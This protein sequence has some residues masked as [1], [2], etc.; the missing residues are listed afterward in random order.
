MGDGASGL[1]HGWLAAFGGHEP[2]KSLSEGVEGGHGS[3]RRG[4]SNV[5]DKIK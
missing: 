2:S 3:V 4:V 5:L 1:G